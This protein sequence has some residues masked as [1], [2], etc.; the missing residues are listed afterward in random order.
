MRT[1]CDSRENKLEK[2][3][4]IRDLDLS[5]LTSELCKNNNLLNQSMSHALSGKTVIYYLIISNSIRG[6]RYTNIQNDI[7]V[8]VS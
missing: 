5:K 6:T 1:K 7:S 3:K 8:D 2:T 4:G